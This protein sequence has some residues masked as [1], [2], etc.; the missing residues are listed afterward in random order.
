MKHKLEIDRAWIGS[1]KNQFNY[2]YAQLDRIPQNIISA[3][4]EKGSNGLYNPD[5]YL[6]YLYS[7]Y[8]DLNAQ[9]KAVD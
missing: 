3:Y 5:K 1:I 6:A 7:C 9:A 8:R 2:I 4:I